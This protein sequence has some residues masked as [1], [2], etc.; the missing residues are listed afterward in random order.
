MHDSYDHVDIQNGVEDNDVMTKMIISVYETHKNT[1]LDHDEVDDA[2][3]H[4]DTDVHDD[5]DNGHCN[6]LEDVSSHFEAHKNTSNNAWINIV[7]D[8]DDNQNGHHV[9][10]GHVSSHHE[11]HKNT[12]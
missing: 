11:A 2:D 12:F 1:Y 10:L 9:H 5:H 3:N 6:H 4:D 8:H 7:D